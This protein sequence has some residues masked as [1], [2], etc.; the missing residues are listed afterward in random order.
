[1]RI[2]TGLDGLDKLI[3][4]G[5]PDKT[6]ILLGG[7]PGTGK[8]LMALNFLIDGAKKGEKCC[9]VSLSE[10]EEELKRA[11]EGIESLRIVDN[12]LNKNLVFKNMNMVYDLNIKYF[13]DTI[14]SY[15]KMDRLVIDNINKLLIFADT[16]K[17][18]RMIFEELLKHLKEKTACSLILCETNGDDIDTGNGEA[19][20]CDGVVHLSFLEFEEKPTRTIKIQKM[21]YTEFEPNV[22]R[23]M[24]INKKEIRLGKAGII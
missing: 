17:S 19:F 23:V 4:G 16:K 10:T 15:P 12:F 6:A 8:T 24:I 2:S 22:S 13:I 1:M 7:G 3:E 20:E 11:A 9:Y 21:R 18:Y 5:F 14:S